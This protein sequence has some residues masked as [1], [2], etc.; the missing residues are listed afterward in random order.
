MRDLDGLDNFSL[1]RLAEIMANAG[2]LDWAAKIA[3]LIR[4]PA[5]MLWTVVTSPVLLADRLDAAEAHTLAA[6]SSEYRDLELAHLAYAAAEIGDRDRAARLTD[7]AAETTATVDDFH[8]TA[9][10]FILAETMLSL[11]DHSRAERFACVIP[12]ETMRAWAV[13]GVRA[14]TGS[15]DDQVLLK[16]VGRALRVGSWSAGQPIYA[17]PR[18]RMRYTGRRERQAF[19]RIALPPAVIASV[20]PGALNALADEILSLGIGR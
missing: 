4:N 1:W 6:P 13:A 11:E 10:L 15:S 2:D 14:A 5:T 17:R 8:K 3:C 20:Q 12:D 16:S 7:R 9:V 18:A 19:D